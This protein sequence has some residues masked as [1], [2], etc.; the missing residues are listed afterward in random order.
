MFPLLSV[1]R[2]SPCPLLLNSHWSLACSL[3]CREGGGEEEGSG[4]L[5]TST[6]GPQQVSVWSTTSKQ[7][8]HTF[9]ISRHGHRRHTLVLSRVAEELPFLV[10]ASNF[11][12]TAWNLDTGACLIQF[13]PFTAPSSSSSS[14]SSPVTTTTTT[15]SASNGTPPSSVPPSP[16][17]ATTPLPLTAPSPTQISYKN[18]RLLM[19]TGNGKDIFFMRMELRAEPP[20]CE[21]L[22]AFTRESGS[23][24]SCCDFY[25]T[26]EGNYVAVL[27]CEGISPPLLSVSFL[28]LFLFLSLSLS[29]FFFFF[30][31][32]LL[33]NNIQMEIYNC[34]T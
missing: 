24:V 3:L 7:L 20:A 14:S 28:F 13:N 27:G 15:T 31:L 9:P 30:F 34:T 8:L 10:A 21:T 26:P 25:Q 5:L 6:L 2:A 16:Q 33:I 11:T 17:P 12:L 18:N 23:R 1:L 22:L 32:L 19:C 4:G 29:L